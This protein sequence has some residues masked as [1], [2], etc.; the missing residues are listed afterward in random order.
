[1]HHLKIQFLK[2]KN[3][4]AN[5][6]YSGVPSNSP[7]PFINFWI[8]CRT[9]PLP[10]FPLSFFPLYSFECLNRSNLTFRIIKQILFILALEVS[11]IKSEIFWFN[12]D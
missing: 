5:Q 4:I 2:A 1:M 10:F 8:F 3:Q 12:R 9:P 6:Y 7:P 11:I